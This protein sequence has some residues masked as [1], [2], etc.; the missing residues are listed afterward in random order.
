MVG[1]SYRWWHM[2]QDGKID[3]FCGKKDML[4]DRYSQKVV[5]MVIDW[6]SDWIADEMGWEIYIDR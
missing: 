4:T 3:G 5:G 1:L 2:A 6:W